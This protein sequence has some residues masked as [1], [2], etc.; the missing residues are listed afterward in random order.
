MKRLKI[1]LAQLAAAHICA[2]EALSWEGFHHVDGVIFKQKY[3]AGNDL[4]LNGVTFKAAAEIR[5]LV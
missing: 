1:E 3:G 4:W 5:A 2:P